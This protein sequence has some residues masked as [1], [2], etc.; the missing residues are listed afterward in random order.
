MSKTTT[1]DLFQV[2]DD[3]YNDPQ[4]K[5]LPQLRQRLLAYAQE[6]VKDGNVALIATKLHHLATLYIQMYPNQ[7]LTAMQTLATKTAREAHFY[8]G[9][10][11]VTFFSPFFF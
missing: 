4:V 7:P 2:I 11:A 10:A 8:D 5:R 3:V 6:L 9:V 1:A